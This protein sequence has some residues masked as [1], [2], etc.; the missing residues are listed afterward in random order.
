MKQKYIGSVR[1]FKHLIILIILIGYFLPLVATFIQS[2]KISKL[3]QK[4]DKLTQTIVTLKKK[5]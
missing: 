5:K 3:E 2:K 1:F 4:V